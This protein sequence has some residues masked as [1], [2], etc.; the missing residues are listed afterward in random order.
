M[1]LYSQLLN[2]LS[3]S[4][5]PILFHTVINASWTISFESSSSFII[6]NATL[7]AKSENL[8]MSDL[9]AVS[10]LLIH[11]LIR[12]PVSKLILFGYVLCD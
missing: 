11:D 5:L 2:F 1:I 12:L 6:L 3:G 9:K 8:L 4:K 10:S 7:N